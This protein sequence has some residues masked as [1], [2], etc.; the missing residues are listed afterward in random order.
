MKIN[1]MT[2]GMKESFKNVNLKSAS[3]PDCHKKHKKHINHFI[4]QPPFVAPNK[5]IY[6]C[7]SDGV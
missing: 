6:G 3:A 1:L 4:K 2:R 5:N 7:W